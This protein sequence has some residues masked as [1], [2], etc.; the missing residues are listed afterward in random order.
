VAPT[1]AAPAQPEVA[2]PAP[3][4]PAPALKAIPGLPELVDVDAERLHAEY[5]IP[6]EVNE[7]VVRCVRKLSSPGAR[8]YF[9]RWLARSH[10]VLPRIRA[11]L[12]EEG[13]PED[14]VYLAMVESGFASNARSR[15]GAVGAWQLLPSTARRYGLRQDPRV[16]ERRDPEKAA[17]AAARFLGE[18]HRQLGDW[19]LAFAAYNA[20]PAR[21]LKARRLGY[22]TFW[23]MARHPGVLPRE[24]RA[25]VPTVLAAAII[26]RHPESF[27]FSNDV[28]AAVERDRRPSAAN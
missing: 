22:D 12:R 20:G 16:D 1:P 23:E 26:A 24:T 5:D 6:I 18:L 28:V 25:Y 3:P 21:I 14:L 17:R 10:R 13:V 11:V 15:A 8:P 9:A 7:Q 2:S 19:H 27:G 4:S